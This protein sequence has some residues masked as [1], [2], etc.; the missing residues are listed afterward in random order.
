MADRYHYSRTYVSFHS[1][2]LLTL[3]Q[4]TLLIDSSEYQNLSMILYTASPSTYHVTISIFPS[5]TY[6]SLVLFPCIHLPEQ[7]H[8]V[9][10]TDTVSSCRVSRQ[11]QGLFCNDYYSRRGAYP[12]QRGVKPIEQSLG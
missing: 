7:A 1:Y 8:E 3:T 10:R 5:Y 4:F 9:S 11:H 12:A 6:I 2:Y